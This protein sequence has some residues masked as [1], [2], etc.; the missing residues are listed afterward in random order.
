MSLLPAIEFE[1]SPQPD[2]TVIWLH[3]LGADGNDFAPIVPELRLPADLSIRF[4]FP[5]APAMPVTINGGFVMPAWYD[6]LEMNIDR[7]VDLEGL[8]ASANEI[9][10]FVSREL[11]RGVDSKRIVI[12]GFSQGGAVAY[13]VA[14]SHEKQLGGLLAMSSYF[15]TADIIRYSEINKTI[16]IKIQHGEHD[17]VVPEELGRKATTQ[18]IK[19]G[20]SVSYQNYPME[21]SVCP[22]QIGVISQWLQA[23]LH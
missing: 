4:I 13:Q 3:G 2:S 9:E 5:H 18:L 14:L 19:Q 15:A 17:S 16:P 23:I 7:K 12:A 11:E 21:H 8:M 1:T 22:E 10:A 20:Y 6:I